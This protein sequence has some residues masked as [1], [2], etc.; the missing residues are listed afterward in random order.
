[1]YENSVMEPYISELYRKINSVKNFNYEW[2]GAEFSN[3]QNFD[4]E[5][6]ILSLFL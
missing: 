2:I 3:L 4:S 1:M 5:K 6:G